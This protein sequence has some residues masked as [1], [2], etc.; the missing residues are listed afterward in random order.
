MSITTNKQT[1]ISSLYHRI[2]F[3][4]GTLIF[5]EEKFGKFCHLAL[6]KLP[7]LVDTELLQEVYV[8]DVLVTWGHLI[9]QGC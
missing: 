3:G 1:N 5:L 8:G 4:Q 7:P 6:S 9:C 2:K